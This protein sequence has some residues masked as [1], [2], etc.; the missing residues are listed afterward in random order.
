M[1]TINAIVVGALITVRL[2]Y[3]IRI[4]AMFLGFHFFR[5]AAE[6]LLM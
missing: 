6:T 4:N 1:E 3:S 2:Y 5:F